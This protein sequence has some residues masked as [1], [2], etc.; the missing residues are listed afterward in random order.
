MEEEAPITDKELSSQLTGLNKGTTSTKNKIILIGGISIIV[1]M[2]IIIIIV[3][4]T[5]SSSS[6]EKNIVFTKQG[7]INCVYDVRSISRNTILLSNEFIKNSNFDI[8]IDGQIIKYSKEY[9]FN[10]ISQKTVKFILYDP[11]VMDFMFKDVFDLVSVQMVS[12]NNLEIKSIASAFE[13]CQGLKKFNISGF[14]TSKVTSMKKLFYRTSISE[15]ELSGL[16]TKNVKDMSYMFAS[17]E[18]IQ[19]NVTSMDTSNVETMASMFQYCRSLV[20]LD[21]SSFNTENVQ[22]MS[23]MFF[24]LQLNGRNK[25]IWIQN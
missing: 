1:L 6:D 4:A 14:D 10:S 20:N 16:N 5:S 19:L 23:Y 18:I 21:L 12:E 13:D 15:L 8:E 9:R 17:T 3:I 11:V 2:I 25:F 24:F 22:D 7:E